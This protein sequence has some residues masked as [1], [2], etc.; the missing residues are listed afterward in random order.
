MRWTALLLLAATA[1]AAAG[2][3]TDTTPTDRALIWAR[4]ADSNSLDPGGISWGEDAKVCEN[5]HETLICLDR[6]NLQPE[7]LLA[8]SWSFSED[9]KTLTFELRKGVKFHNGAELTAEDVA[10]TFHRIIDD[11]HPC[12]PKTPPYAASFTDIESVKADG[13]HR[14]VFTLRRPTPLILSQLAFFP[15]GIVCAAEVK[16]L[17]DE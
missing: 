7:P 8:T 13:P 12:R 17:G 1:A 2:C 10:F 6:E 4:G 9:G 5:I 15:S 3:E 14:A 11:K 16:K